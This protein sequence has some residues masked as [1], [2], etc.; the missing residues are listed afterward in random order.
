MPEIDIVLVAPIYEGNVGFV[1]RV[2]KNFGF[3]RLVLVDPCTL[4]EEASTR[5]SH[6]QDVLHNAVVCA[7]SRT[8]L[9]GAVSWSPR[10]V[11]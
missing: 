6:A 11:R 1:A 5:A 3:C 7:L 8:C 9:P 4:G 10:P 2:M